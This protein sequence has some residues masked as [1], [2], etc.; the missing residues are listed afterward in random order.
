MAVLSGQFSVEEAWADFVVDSLLGI[1]IGCGI[2]GVI[3]LIHRFAP[4][5]PNMD[6][7]ISLATPYLMYL[8]AEQVHASGVLAVVSG[9]LLLSYYS[10]SILPSL[11]KLQMLSVW[12]TLTFV[13]NGLAFIL[14][15]FQLPFIVTHLHLEGI[16]FRLAI[17]FGLLISVSLIGIRLAWMFGTTCL[18]H[19]L[20][21]G[22]IATKRKPD[23]RLIVLTS[24]C[25][26]RG[27]VT[28]A[29]ALSL[30]FSVLEQSH[31]PF[32]SLMIFTAFSV[33]IFTLIVQGL[34][35][36]YLIR[37]LGITQPD[38][39]EM[40]AGA[41]RVQLANRVLHHIQTNYQQ[42]ATT[43]PPFIRQREKYEAILH[44]PLVSGST[45]PSDQSVME[46]R[47]RQ[48]RHELI[49]IQRKELACLRNGHTFPETLIRQK[50]HELDI[51]QVAIL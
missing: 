13:L 6:T 36:P 18:L 17:G 40:K 20:Q 5:T 22:S 44:Q 47:Y 41:L 2:G 15:G 31:F 27:V 23:R 16:S 29:S 28:L 8:T 1:G 46:V 3:Y 48:L 50:E 25:G 34:S 30:P 35:L 9:G 49:S 26:M 51:E 14:V 12:D 45:Q 33:I 10:S 4:T 38:T 21:R 24:W 19:G 32:L 7:I 42:E 39:D 11:A 43:L 37:V